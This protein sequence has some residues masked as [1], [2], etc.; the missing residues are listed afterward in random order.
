MPNSICVPFVSFRPLE[1]E[2]DADLRAAFDRVYSSSRYIGGSEDEAFEKEFADYC[3]TRFCVG[4]GNGLDALTLIL[5]A[6]GIGAGDEVILPANTFVATAL[7]VSYAGAVPVLVDPNPQTFTIDPSKIE[8][9]ITSATRAIIAVHLYGQTADMDSICRIAAQHGLRVFEDAAQAHGARYKGRR[10]GNLGD[11]AAFSFYPGKNLGALGDGGCV[12]TNDPVLAQKVRELG[13]YGSDRKYH[14]IYMGQN[15]RLDELQA[16]FLRVKLPHLDRM[17][18]QRRQVAELYR[19]GMHNPLVTLPAE[20]PD[21]FHVYHIFSVLCQSRN[22]LA[23]HL[24]ELGIGSNMHYPV[25]VHL[26]PAYAGLHIS[27]GTLPQAEAISDTQLSLPLYYGMTG[28]Q[29]HAVIQAVN[30]FAG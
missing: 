28:E 23:A 19:S 21:C 6:S 15:S 9:K 25:P 12:T 20:A 30:S 5:K 24:A 3:G 27:R 26:Q 18:N 7:A 14:H 22:G 8:E 2:L 4:C 10:A 11:A 29:I 17:N 16:A 13:N 1:K